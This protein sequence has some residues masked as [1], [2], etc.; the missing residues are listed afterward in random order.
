[1]KKTSYSDPTRLADVMALI[2]VLACA[3]KDTI[4]TE[5]GLTGVLRGKPKTDGVAFRESV[6]S[7]P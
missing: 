5:E 6:L 1:M 2:Q 7:P 4:R 3:A